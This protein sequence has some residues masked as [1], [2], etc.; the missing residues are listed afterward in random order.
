MTTFPALVDTLADVDGRDRVTIETYVRRLREAGLVAVA[1]RGRNVAIMGLADAANALIGAN[2]S[3]RANEAP[4]AVT[5]FRALRSWQRSRAGSEANLPSEVADADTFGEAVE[6]LIAAAPTIEDAFLDFAAQA[7]SDQSAAFQRAKAL[8]PLA[9][10]WLEVGFTSGAREAGSIRV[11][12]SLGRGPEARLELVYHPAQDAAR[13]DEGA[14]RVTTATIGLPTI[15][16]LHAA[17][18]G[19][20]VVGGSLQSGTAARPAR[21]GESASGDAPGGDL[22]QARA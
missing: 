9:S 10:V 12:V 19:E 7:Y 18:F 5:R 22:V 14:D 2:A 21:E 17:I 16:A 6:A 20:E 3:H 13:G 8:G 15:R 4:G 1:G 11:M